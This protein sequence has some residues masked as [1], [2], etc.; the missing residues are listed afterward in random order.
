MHFIIASREICRVWD[1]AHSRIK[2]I[3]IPEL[4]RGVARH[5]L[6][7]IIDSLAQSTLIGYHDG[8]SVEDSE[9]ATRTVLP[10]L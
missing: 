1:N 9:D 10:L 3:G 8:G 6:R 2:P 7:C 4:L 5:I